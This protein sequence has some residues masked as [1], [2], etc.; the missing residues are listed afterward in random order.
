MAERDWGGIYDLL[1]RIVSIFNNK[2]GVGKTTLSF[3][4]ACALAESGK[5]V[6]LVDLDPQ[7]NLSLH[8]LTEESLSA[9]WD[10]EEDFVDNYGVK[11][12]ENPQKLEEIATRTRSVHFL[13][14]AVEEGVDSLLELPPLHSVRENLWLLPGRLSLHMF[15]NKLAQAHGQLFTNDYSAVRTVTELRNLIR[16]YGEQHD[17]DI[18]ILDTSPSLGL[19]NRYAI[20]FSDGFFSPSSPDLFSLYAFKNIGKSL[21]EWHSYYLSV[22]NVLNISNREKLPDHFVKFLGYT[23]YNAKK[24]SKGISGVEGL[25]STHK[26]YRKQLEGLIPDVIE[27]DLRVNYAD[28]E[29]GIDEAIMFTHN[30]FP[31]V[32]QALKCPI[33]EASDKAREN[34]EVLE[35]LAIAVPSGNHIS[36][37]RKT[38]EDYLKFAV[39]FWRRVE[40][41]DDGN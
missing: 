28:V 35:E 33:W 31:A 29:K 2:G 34:K 18:A 15:E 32:A 20:S 22:Q 24:S 13:L 41:L 6:L 30:T 21:S 10:E 14:K 36:A 37:M 17:A 38:R 3:H 25:A 23:I 39:E 11:R 8:A 5:R 9:I 40:S 26:S 16:K 1:M 7:S 4:L 12:E 27:E 19:L